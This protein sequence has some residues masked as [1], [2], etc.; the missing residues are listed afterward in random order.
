M[1]HPLTARLLNVLGPCRILLVGGGKTEL[2][3]DLLLAGCDAYGVWVDDG[4]GKAPPHP[5]CLQLAEVEEMAGRFDTLVVEAR[6]GTELLPALMQLLSYTSM[7]QHIALAAGGHDRRRLE[8]GLFILGWRRHPGGMALADYAQLRDDVLEELSFYQ[9]IPG[10]AASRWP[11]QALLKDRNLHMD[12]LRESGCRADAHILRYVLAASLIRP[13]DTVVDCACGLGYGS[14]VMSAMSRGAR[15]HAFDLDPEVIDYANANYAHDRLSFAVGDAEAL[16]AIP[17]ASVDMVVSMETIE[18]V[19]DWEKVLAEFRR[20]LRP[21]G[22]LIASVPDRWVDATG[23][24]PNPYHLHA[25][26]W[27]KFAAG[28]NRHFTVEARYLQTAP[29]GFK[30]PQAVRTLQ[31]V[32]LNADIDS[33]W[34]LAVASVDPQEQGKVLRDDFTHPAFERVLEQ[35][36]APAVAFAEAYDNPYL[37]R[38]LV[39][40]GERLLDEHALVD[41]AERTVFTSDRN[42]ADLGAALSVLGY[43]ALEQRDA[44]RAHK[45]LAR[46]RIYLDDTETDSARPHI[47]RWRLSLTFLAGRLAAMLG[48]RAEALGWFEAAAQ[49]DWRPFSPI[50]ATKAVAAAFHAG[51]L[52]LAENDEERARG[53]FTQ[54]LTQALAAA[55]SPASSIIGSLAVPIPFALQE[56]AEVLDM[57]GQCAVALTYLPVWRSSPGLF[58]Q[59]VD[60][61]RFGLATW[62]MDLNRLNEQLLGELRNQMA[63]NRHLMQEIETLRRVNPP[64]GLMRQAA[65]R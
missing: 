42:S 2:L 11:V 30:L 54:G 65:A 58:W 33:E 59:Q 4:T 6:P 48:R 36:K 57:G 52:C 22:R 43:R 19:P 12:M 50:V 56:L 10:E 23:R 61:K 46:I 15:F 53:C 38:P 49:F 39:Q 47:C 64:Q 8:T 62:A 21:D 27:Q 32:A 14:A 28:L 3:T 18:H 16:R 17:D 25:F 7:P 26:D 37:Y 24:D 51:L 29:G 35:S 63:I 13:G 44:E 31:R 1:P 5:R 9:R 40:M 20:I 55:S 60:I 34:L 41:L 45:L